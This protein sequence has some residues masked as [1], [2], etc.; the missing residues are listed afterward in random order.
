MRDA[1]DRIV[2]NGNSSILFQLSERIGSMRPVTTGPSYSSSVNVVPLSSVGYSMSLQSMNVVPISSI[3]QKT[4]S[5]NTLLVK[6][7]EDMYCVN[8]ATKRVVV[9]SGVSNHPDICEWEL[10]EC[11]GLSELVV[12]D[13]CLQF[14]KEL[15]L[16]GLCY[17]EKVEIGMR[18][19]CKSK[20]CFEVNG[21]E[22]L[23]SVTIGG[24][25]FSNWHFFTLKNCE[26]IAEVS[27][28]DGCFVT[29]DSI[30]F[31]G[32]NCTMD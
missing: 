16:S 9:K 12:G 6:E 15:K 4:D 25:S 17:L 1:I 27:I 11:Q 3:N 14:V 19:F 28:G 30:V 32:A 24:G 22:K 23:K 21:C 5:E 31:E 2:E 10:N 8:S 20:G 7:D 18:C 13:D 26:S 29:C